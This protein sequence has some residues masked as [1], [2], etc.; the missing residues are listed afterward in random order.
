MRLQVRFSAWSLAI[1]AAMALAAATTTLAQVMKPIAGDP[2]R[3]D[4]GQVAGSLAA[5]GVKTDFGIPFAA[6]P[7]RENRWREPQPAKPWD[8]ILTAT[9]MPAEWGGTYPARADPGLGMVRLGRIW[10]QV[11][12]GSRPGASGSYWIQSV[13]TSAQ[14]V[15]RECP[16]ADCGNWDLVGG[17]PQLRGRLSRGRWHLLAELPVVRHPHLG[18]CG[19]GE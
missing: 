1:G 19:D 15:P 17:V 18:G 13:R 5:G 16:S 14:C 6:P 3:I 9:K 2:A 4:A 12:L 7:I 11:G 10:G 8:G